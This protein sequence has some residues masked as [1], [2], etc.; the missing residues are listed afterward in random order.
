MVDLVRALVAAGERAA[1]LPPAGAVA[2]LSDVIDGLSGLEA[3]DAAVLGYAARLTL[4]PRTL[5]AAHLTPL[6][7]AGLGDG[8]V[9][10]VA[11]VVACFN[12]MN[13][14]ADGLGVVQGASNG[15]W[16]RQLLGDAAW[17]RHQAW[18]RPEGASDPDGA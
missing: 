4:A 13:R 14:L 16:A 17:A 6:R 9:H 15:A 10:D 11:H 7:A 5:R 3:G 2:H 12:Y 1:A 8:D 18:G